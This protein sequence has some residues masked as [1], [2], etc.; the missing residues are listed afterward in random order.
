MSSDASN[1][2]ASLSFG[3]SS[4]DATAAPAAAVCGKCGTALRASYHLIGEIVACAKCRYAAQ[5]EAENGGDSNMGRATAYGIAAALGV[6]V[7]NYAIA[8]A[9]G[10]DV[11]VFVVLAAF[12]AGQ[13]VRVGSR[14]AGGRKYQFLAI[15]MAYLAMG[16]AYV[17]LVI[18]AGSAAS[19]GA[20]VVAALGAPLLISIL[21]PLYGFFIALALYRAWRRNGGDGATAVPVSVSGPFRLQ[22]QGGPAAG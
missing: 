21:N 17:P 1:P 7:V 2:R 18:S 4:F 10:S 19:T 6:A 20:L 14:Y 8:K 22:Q 12:A 16:A 5:A 11:P 3:P 9:S 13:A 15:A